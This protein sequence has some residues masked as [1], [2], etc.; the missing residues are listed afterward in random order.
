MLLILE[1]TKIIS[2]NTKNFKHI[3]YQMR[4]ELGYEKI[5]IQV[6]VCFFFLGGGLGFFCN[7]S[8]VY[9]SLYRNEIHIS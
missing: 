8:M 6:I 1:K 5:F 9:D 4:L 2:N 7:P 3:Y